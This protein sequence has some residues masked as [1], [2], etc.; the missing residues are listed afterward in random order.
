MRYHPE[1][2]ESVRE[3]NNIVDIIGQYTGLKSK[4]RQHMGLCPFPDHNEKSPSFSVSEDKQLYHCFG[5]K[6]S[7]NLFTFLQEHNGMTFLD[8]LEFLAR[9]AGIEMPK[10]DSREE[11]GPQR[12]TLYKINRFAASFF[13][14]HLTEL[15]GDHPV[16]KY[17][18]QRGLTQEFI[19]EFKLGYA[20]E[21]WDSLAKRLQGSRAP[22]PEAQSLGLIKQRKTGKG[23]FDLFRHRLIF[24]ILSAQEEVLGFGG[25][26]LNKED[27][28]KY[29]N[30]P[31]SKVFH[32]GRTFYGL[33]LTGKHIRQKNAAI[34]VEGY[35]D[36]IALYKA[37]IKNVVATLGTAM[38][39][40]HVKL[41][42]RYTSR[43]I[44]MFDGDMAGQQA[45]EKSLK[46][47]FSVG[48]GPLAVMLPSHQDPDDFINEHG[49]EALEE[50]IAQ[51]KELF[52]LFLQKHLK[53][54]KYT[55]VEK[56]ELVRVVKP[57]LIALSDA[58]L[59]AL[60]IK[61]VAQRMD[62]TERWVQQ[63]LATTPNRQQRSA[64][65]APVPPPPS[66]P[67]GLPPEAFEPKAAPQEAT[68][69]GELEKM[70]LKKV[71]KTEV[72]LVGLAANHLES[73]ELIQSS[74]VL[75]QLASRGVQAILQRIFDK[76]R[77]NP[78]GFDKLAAS[79]VSWVERPEELTEVF[80]LWSQESDDLSPLKTTEQCIKRVQ[81]GFL[82]RQSA[83]LAGQLRNEASPEKLEQIMNINKN[84][85]QLRRQDEDDKTLKGEP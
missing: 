16:K 8:A 34:V 41:L 26:V 29:L 19:E 70:S 28:P 66:D 31:E 17:C 59:K 15:P 37:G 32:K 1:F 22:L 79:V 14:H 84:R 21:S 65:N 45:A 27:K 48:L 82:R 63:Q 56:M 75:E 55:S 13:H 62:V 64:N 69:E 44:L 49:V 43:V 11:Q 80:N 54:F 73:L 24:P 30:S 5:C 77:Q 47:V 9:R 71:P 76:Y 57:Y 58:G 50:K 78:S 51:A 33:N 25:R 72:Y 83:L 36:F 53:D 6:K 40:D 23:H 52:T 46:T 18:Q 61:E 85:I 38:T 7:G 81:E 10:M 4:G 68:P 12:S 67:Y 20:P 42:K 60:Y 2:V 39:E 3:A 35:M 74:G